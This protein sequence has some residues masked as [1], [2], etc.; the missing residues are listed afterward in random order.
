[1]S[2]ERQMRSPGFLIAKGLVGLLLV[3]TPASAE[4]IV[5]AGGTV[6]EIVYALG[7]GG[8]LVAVDS[9]SVYPPEATKLPQIGYQRTLAAEGIVSMTPTLVLIT[10]ESGPPPAIEQLR[11]AGLEVLQVPTGH[12]VD[13]TRAAI[14]AIAARLH[15]D[16]QGEELVRALD[17]DVE[18]A[19]ARAAA[20]T[21]R[22]KVLFVYARGAGNAMVSGTGTAADE[23]IR[24]AGAVNAVSDYEGFRPLTAE[25]AVAAA[26]E[27]VLVPTRGLES[28][29]GKSALFSQPGIAM[30]PAAKGERVVAMD[31]LYLLGFGPRVGKALVELTEALHG[32]PVGTTE[33]GR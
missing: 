3:A 19:R 8:E 7:V 21:S 5:A 18:E 12:S 24:L 25:G 13:S 22:P 16:K 31:D 28:L 29:G 1:M 15:R 10:P 26:P 27:I 9:S 14:R 20:V 11:A 33:G 17:A 30:T 6:T 4:R 23:M 2:R 32:T